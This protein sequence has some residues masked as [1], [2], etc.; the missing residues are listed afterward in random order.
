MHIVTQSS[1]SNKRVLRQ[2]SYRDAE[3]RNRSLRSYQVE[4]AFYAHAAP[5]LH[6]RGVPVPRLHACAWSGD[7]L[8]GVTVLEDLTSPPGHPAAS[9]ATSAAPP[10]TPQARTS[11]ARV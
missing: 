7:C 8:Q 11:A 2:C 6:A 1:P 10:A 4:R 3:H 5:L 9:G